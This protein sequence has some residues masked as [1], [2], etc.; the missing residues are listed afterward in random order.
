MDKKNNQA[1]TLR[2]D[3]T[4]TTQYNATLSPTFAG[5]FGTTGPRFTASSPRAARVPGSVLNDTER[6]LIKGFP[7][8]IPPEGLTW[9]RRA[10]V[11]NN[12]DGGVR[13]VFRVVRGGGGLP[14]GVR[15]HRRVWNV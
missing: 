5:R 15:F 11:P 12:R 6:E 9:L 8:E 2:N 4:T 1:R 10:V 7:S 13:G 14:G 3:K